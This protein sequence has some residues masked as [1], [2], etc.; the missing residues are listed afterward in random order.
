LLHVYTGSV[1]L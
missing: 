1:R